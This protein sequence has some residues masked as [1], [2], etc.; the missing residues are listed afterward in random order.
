MVPRT[1]LGVFW[2]FQDRKASGEQGGDPDH[3]WAGL[4][5]AEIVEDLCVEHI[6]TCLWYDMSRGDIE[7]RRPAHMRFAIRWR[8]ESNSWLLWLSSG[9]LV[10]GT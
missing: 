6:I 9:W 5:F 4:A 8:G 7:V 1:W 10:G 2:G 3:W